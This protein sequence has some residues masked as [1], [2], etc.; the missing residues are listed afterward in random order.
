MTVSKVFAASYSDQNW[1]WKKE[2]IPKLK[3]GENWLHKSQEKSKY[4]IV[5]NDEDHA[6]YNYNTFIKWS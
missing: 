3:L 2:A 1:R 4:I 6:G 5:S